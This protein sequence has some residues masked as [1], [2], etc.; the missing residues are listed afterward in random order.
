[1]EI[2]HRRSFAKAISWRIVGTIDTIVLALLLTGSVGDSF[3]IGGIEVITK[4][5]L[6]YLHERGWNLLKWGIK[7]GLV[8]HTRSIIK[9][10]S[11]RLTGSLDTVIISFFVTGELVL[12]MKIGSA[13]FITKIILYYLHERVWTKIN[14]GKVSLNEKKVIN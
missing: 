4:I 5:V 6:F 12:A 1:M 7:D 14:W 10:F 2:T 3:K 9:S 11:W 8:I 13:E